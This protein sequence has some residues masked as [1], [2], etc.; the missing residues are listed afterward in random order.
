MLP[1][2]PSFVCS[3]TAIPAK[4]VRLLVLTYT[5]SSFFEALAST[6]LATIL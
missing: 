2:Q 6:I 3:S 4:K 1:D 5:A